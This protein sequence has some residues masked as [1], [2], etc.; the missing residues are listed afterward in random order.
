[1]K[2]SALFIISQEYIRFNRLRISETTISPWGGDKKECPLVFFFD[3]YLRE[4]INERSQGRRY[5]SLF[6]YRLTLRSTIIT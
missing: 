3:E 1:M 5:C 2:I 6:A 4:M